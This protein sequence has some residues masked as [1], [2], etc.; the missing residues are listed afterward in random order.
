M[1]EIALRPFLPADAPLLI[2]IFRDSVEVLAQDEYDEDQRSAWASAA[3]DEQA[4][5]ERLGKAL[6]IIAT[7]DGE[8]AGFAS[9]QGN[10]KIDMLYVDPSAARQGV[11]TALA[12]ALEK[13]GGARGAKRITADVS[14]TARPF[15]EKRGY[16]AQTRNTIEMNGEWLANTTM[17]RQLAANEAGNVPPGGTRH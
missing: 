3:D 17:I 14:D 2:D 1:P 15:F 4:F 7:V 6:T 11:G 5:A 10:D 12:D 16:V 8:P 13:L 9:L